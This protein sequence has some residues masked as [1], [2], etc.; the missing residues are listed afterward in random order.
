MDLPPGF[1]AKKKKWF[2]PFHVSLHFFCIY[3]CPESECNPLKALEELEQKKCKK[4]SWLKNVIWFCAWKTDFFLFKVWDKKKTIFSAC[5]SLIKYTK[6]L[7]RVIRGL[8]ESNFSL[9]LQSRWD[10]QRWPVYQEMGIKLSALHFV[11][12]LIDHLSHNQP[13]TAYLYICYQIKRLCV[14]SVYQIKCKKILM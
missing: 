4:G 2:S 6:W 13:P 5:C 1:S 7:S 12:N 8:T 11:D 3:W 14:W 9:L 10:S